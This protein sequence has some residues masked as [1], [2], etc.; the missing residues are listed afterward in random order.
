MST[1]AQFLGKNPA[2]SLGWAGQTGH[3]GAKSAAARFLKINRQG[4]QGLS[5]Q[6]LSE[7]G[8]GKGYFHENGNGDYQ[9]VQI[10]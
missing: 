1:A 7:A 6:S 5:A 9:A 10:G 4:R 2:G 3:S 8:P